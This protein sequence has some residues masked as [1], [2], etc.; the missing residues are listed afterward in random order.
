MSKDIEIESELTSLCEEFLKYIKSLY[1]QGLINSDQYQEM[2][3]LKIKYL[4]DVKKK[5]YMK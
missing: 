4:E 2:S 3:E 1:N 5:D